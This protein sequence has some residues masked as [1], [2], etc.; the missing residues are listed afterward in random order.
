[1]SYDFGFGL[2]GSGLGVLTREGRQNSWD[3]VR[4]IWVCFCIYGDFKQMADRG[5]SG[6]DIPSRAA[7]ILAGWGVFIGIFM[8]GWIDR[9]EGYRLGVIDSIV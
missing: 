3:L 1:M 2:V 6:G 9:K 8:D 7:L 5:R 4:D